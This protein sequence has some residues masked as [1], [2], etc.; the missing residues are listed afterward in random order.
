MVQHVFPI[1]LHRFGKVLWSHIKDDVL[2]EAKDGWGVEEFTKFV[3]NDPQ[4]YRTFSTE[5]V[6][7]RNLMVYNYIGILQV[8]LHSILNQFW[9]VH[10][11][12]PHRIINKEEFGDILTEV[13]DIVCHDNLETFDFKVTVL[14]TDGR[15]N[16]L[17]VRLKFQHRRPQVLL[18]KQNEHKIL[19]FD[20]LCLHR[21]TFDMCFN[22]I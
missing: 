18:V 6:Y 12:I 3:F 11:T 17:D 16:R 5:W 15:E 10:T 8:T 20:T 21:Y 4:H 14:E 9:H 22:V 13:D 2:S 7:S 1:C 19:L